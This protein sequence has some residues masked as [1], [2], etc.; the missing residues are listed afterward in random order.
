DRRRPGLTVRPGD[1][2]QP[3]YLSW[4]L[5]GAV[6]DRADQSSYAGVG[7][8]DILDDDV[9]VGGEL[10]CAGHPHG[11]IAV[12]RAGARRDACGENLRRR[13][14]Q[15]NTDALISLA[16]LAGDGAR[17]V[18]DDSPARTDIVVD[19]GADAVAIAV[20]VPPQRERAGRDALIEQ[21]ARHRVVIL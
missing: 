12:A 13:R 1:R 14:H 16:R 19:P 7:M 6:A 21:R 8:L 20:R 3:Q 2:P 17:D 10:G 15:D 9:S 5:A 11:D 4:V 18:A